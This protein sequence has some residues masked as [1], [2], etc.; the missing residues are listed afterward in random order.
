MRAH[1]L[2]IAL[3]VLAFAIVIGDIILASHLL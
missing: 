3:A 1:L 2:Q